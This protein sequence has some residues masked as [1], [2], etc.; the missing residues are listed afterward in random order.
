MQQQSC[1]YSYKYIVIKEREILPGRDLN[2]HLHEC[3][4]VLMIYDLFLDTSHDLFL[5]IT[6][7]DA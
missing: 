5:N 3:K 6:H 7:N 1:Y 4:V 2:V